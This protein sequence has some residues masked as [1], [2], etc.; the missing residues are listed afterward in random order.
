MELENN[1]DTL[2]E[3]VNGLNAD[4]GTDPDFGL[5]NAYDKLTEATKKGD[6]LPKYVILFTDGEPTGNSDD[7]SQGTTWST[8]AQKRA[9]ATAKKLKDNGVSI[10]TIGFDLSEKAQKFLAGYKDG[11][12]DYPGIASSAECA[13]TAKDAADLSE[14]FR[15]FEQT[16]FNDVDITNATITDTIDP[17]FDLLDDA[18]N[19]ITEE[20][21]TLN[22]GGVARLVNGNWQVQ[23]T[24]VTIPNKKNNNNNPWTKSLK[25]K[26][27]DT[28]IGGNDVT[29]NVRDGSNITFGNEKIYLPQPKVN[30]NAKILSMIK[31]LPFIRV[32][33]FRQMKIF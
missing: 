16:I 30:V 17:R 11:S 28:Y 12:D 32:I 21:F 14:L 29:T 6:T 18:G 24:N 33:R 13:K 26:A 31:K 4:G 3:T 22:N 25:I 2:I 19:I 1:K 5:N 8:A 27:K 9:E 23:W 7:I 20:P 15:T 10:Y